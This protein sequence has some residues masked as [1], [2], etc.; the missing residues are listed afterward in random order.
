MD[1]DHAIAAHS[2]WKSKLDGY[3]KN[4]DHSLKPAE[5]GLDDHCDLGK[6]IV[7]EG[8]QFSKL[9]E[10]VSLKS[11]HSRF[12]KAAASVIQHADAGQNVSEEIALGGKSE[13]SLAS[14]AVVRAIMALKSKAV[15]VNAH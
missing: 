6:W 2:S 11:E 9:P 3:L 1:F 14:A 7:G 4:P 5:V 12:H 15:P 8:K 13:F 10:Y